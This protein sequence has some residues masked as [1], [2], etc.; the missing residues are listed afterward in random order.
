MPIVFT[1][2]GRGAMN[3]MRPVAEAMA[4]D[5]RRFIYDR[6][7]CGASDITISGEESEQE[8]WADDLAQFIKQLDIGPAYL[9][10]WSAGCRVSLLTAIRHPELVRGLLLGWVTGGAVAAERLAYQYYGQFIEA[11]QTGG[12]AAVVTTPYFTERI[13]EN[14]ANRER[15]LSMDVQEFIRV[16]SRWRMFFTEG[17]DLPVIGATEEELASIQVPTVIIAGDDD[18]HTLP[19]AQALHRILPNAQFHSP[20]IQRDEWDRLW[21][22]PPEALAQARA[23]RAAPI[24]KEFLQQLTMGQRVAES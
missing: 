18:I 16:M 5:Y 8:I 22:G 20:V 1:P 11:A 2:G 4:P 15:L 10:G 3:I 6:R 7:N 9:G 23:E 17:A 19:A 14:S 24:F 21:E 13:T 12:M